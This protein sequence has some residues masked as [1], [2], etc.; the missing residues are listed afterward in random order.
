MQMMNDD[1]ISTDMNEDERNNK[2][3]IPFHMNKGAPKLQVSVI[4]IWTKI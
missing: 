1:N 3:R 2:V 4:E